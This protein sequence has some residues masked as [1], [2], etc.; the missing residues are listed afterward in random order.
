MECQVITE[1][2]KQILSVRKKIQNN[3]ESSFFHVWFLKK[4]HT[5]SEQ[6]TNSA[7][8]ILEMHMCMFIWSM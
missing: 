3:L 2:L 6:C 5:Q 4:L 1:P 7:L 8:F